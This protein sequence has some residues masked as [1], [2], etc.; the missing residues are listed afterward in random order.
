MSRLARPGRGLP[1]LSRRAGLT[2][3]LLSALALAGCG[4]AARLD[5]LADQGRGQVVEVISGDSVRLDSGD[6]V[7]LAGI[8]APRWDQPGGE[9]ARQALAGLTLG[10]TV[11]L[12][13]AGSREDPFGRRMAH[14]RRVKGRTWVQG[15]LL[16]D[17]AVRVRT[18][19]DSRALA[20]L[21][22]AHEA[23]ARQGRRGLWADRGY[24]VRL[25]AEALAGPPGFV[26]VEGRVKS[27]WLESD[28]RRLDLG[29]GLVLAL[30]ARSLGDFDSAGLAPASLQG[31][32]LRVR[33]YLGRD[34]E[35][36][37]DH[38]EAIEVLRDG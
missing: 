22:L 27:G 10:Q 21:M 4:E 11:E 2:L 37:I 12:L 18:F 23:R 3:A 8:T 29:S 34:G 15:R 31:R 26:L 6:V 30:P 1:A 36:R 19:A 13:S 32:L 20:G 14:L 16:E 33:G 28:G 35:M 24:Q 7:K 9:A 25:P 38:P 17:G 5:S